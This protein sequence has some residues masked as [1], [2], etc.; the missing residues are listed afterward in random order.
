LRA[1]T[2]PWAVSL[3]AQ[4]AA[5]RAL[6]DPAYY[7]SR[8]A[9]TRQLRQ[10]LGEEL[11]KLGWEVIPGSANFLLCHLPESGPP[12]DELIQ[13]CQREGLFLRN[14]VTMGSELGSRSIRIAAKD[15]ATNARVLSII[16]ASQQRLERRK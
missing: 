9:E 12:A 15:A 2:P 7:A 10:Q 4:V 14:P 11:Q 3:P 5:S 1:I 13:Q 6:E 8:Y 16:D